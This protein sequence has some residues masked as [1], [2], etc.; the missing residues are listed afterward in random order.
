[1]S[2][3]TPV[4]DRKKIRLGLALLTVVF[5]A[6]VVLFFVTDDKLGRAVFFGVA[7]VLLVRMTLLVRGMRKS[8]GSS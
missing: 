4:V 6:A 1:M 2:D 5:A 7:V 8:G 3:P